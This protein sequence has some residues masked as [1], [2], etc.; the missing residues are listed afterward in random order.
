MRNILVTGA[1]KGIGL[2]I[3]ERILG[4]HEDT[5]VYLGSR[6]LERGQAAKAGLGANASRVEVVAL[7]VANARSVQD[8]KGAITQPLYGIVN[9]AGVND[10]GLDLRTVIETN[11]FGTHRVTETFLPQLVASGRLVN[12]SSASGPSWVSSQSAEVQRFFLDPTMTWE[13][14]E[15]FIAEAGNAHEG[16]AYGF[17]KACVNLLTMIVAREHP[18][19]KVNGCTP[20][21]IAT[22]MTRHHADATGKTPSDLGM[23]STRD[24]A[25]VP[26]WLLFGTPE[27]NGRFYGSDAKRSPLDR[28]RSPGSAEYVGP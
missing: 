3:V 23:K 8:A 2:A 12:I 10:N 17:S 14:L 18:T 27:G 25:N 24:G 19:L 21:Y 15:A 6:D 16:S 20:G 1:N 5:F 4:E 11:V 28:Y 13:R 7:D 22:D 26:L 9:N